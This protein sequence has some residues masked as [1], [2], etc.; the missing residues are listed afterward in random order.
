MNLNLGISNLRLYSDLQ[1]SA[2]E[3]VAVKLSLFILE[4]SLGTEEIITTII[5]S[6]TSGIASSNIGN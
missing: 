1:S 5:I 4:R 2:S 6:I 3:G